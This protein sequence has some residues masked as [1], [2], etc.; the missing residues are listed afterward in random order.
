MNERK[1]KLV[2]LLSEEEIKYK[3]KELARQ[4]DRDYEGVPPLLVGILTGSFIFAADLIREL[5]GNYE[6]DFLATS[7]YGDSTATSGVVRLLKDLNT[8]IENRDVLLIEDIVDTGLTLHYICE[9]LELRGPKSLN[10]VTLLDKEIER[11]YV[12]PIKYVGFKVPNDFLVG[13]GL[14]WAHNYRGLPYVA[15]VKFESDE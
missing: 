13:Y 6:V 10:I 8:S 4:L 14:D 7:S 11:D 15:K 1:H 12:L 9:I 2:E 5:H 3:V